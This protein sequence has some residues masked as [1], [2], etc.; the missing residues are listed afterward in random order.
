ME[1]TFFNLKTYCI[2][3]YCRFNIFGPG[4]AVFYYLVYKCF[5][6]LSSLIQNVSLGWKLQTT[7]FPEHFFLLFQAIF[8]LSYYI[9]SWVPC[10]LLWGPNQTKQ[11]TKHDG[12]RE[13]FTTRLTHRPR[14]ANEISHGLTVEEIELP[15]LVL[16]WRNALLMLWGAELNGE[17]GACTLW[18]PP[19]SITPTSHG[20]FLSLAGL[21]A[22]WLDLGSPFPQCQA[23][24]WRPGDTQGR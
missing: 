5:A 16:D 9:I 23:A 24:A 8:C 13:V 19:P 1:W 21:S 15:C 10:C 20:H 14:D 12:G 17:G 6:E 18:P 22:R 4:F 2:F 11:W 7:K 3:A